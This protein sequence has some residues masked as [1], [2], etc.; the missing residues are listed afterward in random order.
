[1]NESRI[2]TKNCQLF[3][4]KG[5]SLGISYLI[6]SI[7]ANATT[8]RTECNL[9]E[10]NRCNLLNNPYFAIMIPSTVDNKGKREQ[11]AS[12]G[13]FRLTRHGLLRMSQNNCKK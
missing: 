11:A 9:P 7:D 3:P 6:I 8:R 5:L 2:S 12:N 13:K 4:P 10:I 1:M